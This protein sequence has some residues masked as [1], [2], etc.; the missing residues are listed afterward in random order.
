MY[1]EARLCALECIHTVETLRKSNIASINDSSRKKRRTWSQSVMR[2][3]ADKFAGEEHRGT[4]RLGLIRK[5]WTWVPYIQRPV[6]GWQCAWSWQIWGVSSSCSHVFGSPFTVCLFVFNILSVLLVLFCFALT[7]SIFW[8]SVWWSNREWEA[9]AKPYLC[10]L[11][12]R[13]PG[14]Q[15][16]HPPLPELVSFL[17]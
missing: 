1:P 12:Q 11:H 14:R 2:S 10:H 4:T 9:T 6:C 8:V 15:V 5:P 13:Q 16:P 7:G 3:L 17:S